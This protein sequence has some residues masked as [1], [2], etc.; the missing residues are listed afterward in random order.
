M[1]YFLNLHLIDGAISF[2][3]GCYLGQEIIARLYFKASPK[4]WLHRVAGTGDVPNAGEKIGNVD[5]VNSIATDTGFEALVVA[6][7]DDIAASNLTILELPQ[8]LQ[9]PVARQH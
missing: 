1:I 7:P 8:A 5:V 3:K 6:R 9:Q 2:K 4:A